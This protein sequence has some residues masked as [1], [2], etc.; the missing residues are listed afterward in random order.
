MKK[1]RA[2]MRSELDTACQFNSNKKDE[3][4]QTNMLSSLKIQALSLVLC[5]IKLR[6]IC[7][8]LDLRNIS[9][10]MACPNFVNNLKHI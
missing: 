10:Q 8:I 9:I 5:Q 2:M 3:I 7:R 1:W 4:D 6:L